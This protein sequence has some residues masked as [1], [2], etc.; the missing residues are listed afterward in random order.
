MKISDHALHLAAGWFCRILVGGVFLFSGLA[1]GIDPFGTLY[2]FREYLSVLDIILPD[3]VILTGVILLCG[4]EFL[5]GLFLLSGCY[6][7]GAAW[8]A[9]SLMVPMLF[10]TLWIYIADPV[11]DCG[12]FGDVLKLSNSAT[13]WKNVVLTL[14]SVWLVRNNRSLP[15]LFTPY[16]Q[17]IVLVAGAIVIVAIALYGYDFQPIFDFRKYP[18]GTKLAAE[19]P[20]EEEEMVF[21][22]RRGDETVRVSEQDELPSEEDGWVFVDRVVKEPASIDPSRHESEGKD[23]DSFR[24]YDEEGEDVTSDLLEEGENGKMLLILI[25]EIERVSKAEAWKIEELASLCQ[26]ADVKCV[27]VT[28]GSPEATDLWKELIAADIPFYTSEDTS[29]KTLARGNPAVVYLENDVIQWKVTLRGLFVMIRLA[30]KN[31]HGAVDLFNE[32]QP[33]H[34]VTESHPG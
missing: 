10:I 34:L 31:G 9:L 32:K 5:T 23:I 28:A 27:M 18:V 33:Y 12:C 13:F 1:K 29:I 7:R 22:Y 20:D 4:F 2:K 14:A 30:S 21:I 25:P 19:S 16:L 24:I 6:R 11:S 8:C 3:S 15:T 26:E 17:W